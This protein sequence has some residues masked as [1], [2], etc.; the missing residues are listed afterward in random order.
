MKEYP[1]QCYGKEMSFEVHMSNKMLNVVCYEV[2]K[3]KLPPKLLAVKSTLFT[4]ILDVFFWRIQEIFNL[5]LL[6]S[7]GS[8]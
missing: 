4:D 8:N 3:V 6:V 1:W 2:Y 7:G 5:E